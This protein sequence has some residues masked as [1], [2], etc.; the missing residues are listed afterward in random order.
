MKLVLY[1]ISVFC[2]SLVLSSCC[3]KECGD[4]KILDEKACEC[5]VNIEC[6][7][8]DGVQNGNET[9]IDCGGVKC[10]ECFDCFS[11][12][13]T[14]LSG[15]TFLDKQTSITWKCTL[16]DGEPFVIDPAI[17]ITVIYGAMRFKF[18]NKGPLDFT[19]TEGDA[20]GRWNFDDPDD[21][22]Q[23]QLK[24]VNSEHE[25]EDL[26]LVSLK[27]NEFVINWFGVLATFEPGN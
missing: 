7:C 11:N 12:F 22:T 1:L 16:I 18:S 19:S 3:N 21:P 15:G 25:D 2:V 9:G 26:P 23:I 20:K 4:C 13:C 10:I 14:Y 24:F 27:E 8:N 17:L 5:I 6:L